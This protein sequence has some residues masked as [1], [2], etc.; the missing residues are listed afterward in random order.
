VALHYKRL[1]DRLDNY[2]SDIIA[3]PLK[4]FYHCNS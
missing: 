2:L 4:R 1:F 3:Q